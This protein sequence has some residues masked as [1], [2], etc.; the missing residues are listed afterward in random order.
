MGNRYGPRDAASV[1]M[2]HG[3]RLAARP[4]HMGDYEMIW[5]YTLDG[6]PASWA[7]LEDKAEEYEPLRYRL[8]GRGPRLRR[9]SVVTDLHR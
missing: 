1:L 7:Q 3:H 9:V 5:A 6:Q 4:D 8:T 2:G